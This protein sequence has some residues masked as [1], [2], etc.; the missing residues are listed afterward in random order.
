MA[1][2][3]HTALG[4]PHARPS[5][6]SPSSHSPPVPPRTLERSPFFSVLSIPSGT[7]SRTIMSE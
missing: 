7:R 6:C 3:A 2:E 1:E 4:R 5:H